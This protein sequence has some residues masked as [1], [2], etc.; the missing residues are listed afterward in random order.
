MNL[1]VKRFLL[2]LLHLRSKFEFWDHYVMVVVFFQGEIVRQ[3]KLVLDGKVVFLN[4]FILQLQEKFIFNLIPKFTEN[5]L[6]K[7]ELI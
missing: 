1:S 6:N 2:F 7:E 3:S 4:Y 5:L